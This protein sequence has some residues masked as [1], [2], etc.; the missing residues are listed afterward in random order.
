MCELGRTTIGNKSGDQPRVETLAW[1]PPTSEWVYEKP[2]LRMMSLMV[3]NAEFID[4]NK[5]PISEVIRKRETKCFRVQLQQSSPRSDKDDELCSRTKAMTY[6]LYQ[7]VSRGCKSFRM[8]WYISSRIEDFS[9]IANDIKGRSGR[10]RI[11][12]WM[13]L[14]VNNFSTFDLQKWLSETISSQLNVVYIVS[15]IGNGSDKIIQ[16]IL[17]HHRLNREKQ[18][19]IPPSKTEIE[20]SHHDVSHH[21]KTSRSSDT[22]QA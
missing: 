2:E 7:E 12:I 1:S 6:Y 8:S 18:L 3:G 16:S 10:G 22:R 14:G 5:K 19:Y 21:L 11:L 17:K 15:S 4:E 20:L 9:R 13:D